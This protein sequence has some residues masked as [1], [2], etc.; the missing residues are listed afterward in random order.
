MRPSV[1]VAAALL[2]VLV[3]LSPVVS[4][5]GTSTPEAAP[6]T[7]SPLTTDAAAL[8]TS[9]IV[10]PLP[11][12]VMIG[13]TIGLAYPHPVALASYLAAVE[14]PGSAHY[15]QFLTHGEFE[16]DFAPSAA[17]AATVA[18]TLRADGGIDVTV[19]PDRLSVSG[20]LPAGSADSLF[21]VSLVSYRSTGGSLE[22][23]AV[24][25]P[26]LPPSWVGVVDAIDGLSNAA[27]A[28]L[29]GLLEVSPF[30]PTPLRV[31][32]SPQYA[33]DNA[34]GDQWF[35]GS[36]Y[37]NSFD[38]QGLLPGYSNSITNATYPTG[39]AIATLLASGWNESLNE[40]TPPWD[41]AVVR[42]YFNDTLAPDWL[43]VS[44]NAS[45]VGVPI[46]VDGI[47][48]PDPGPFGSVNDSTLDT[49]ENA[50]DLEMAGSLAPGASLY[51]FYFAG[52]LLE[53]GSDSDVAGFFDQDLAAALAYNYL[54]LI[55][56]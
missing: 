34:T 27:N 30:V 8:P 42:G 2:V 43:N 37:T 50:L 41:P 51:N 48:P 7:S 35:V 29:A 11:S 36:D 25:T 13:L 32:G 12:S 26:R 54:S 38:V 49:F 6:L 1:S 39:E 16:S 14:S 9:A 53:S 44:R 3:A 20:E 33:T 19:A 15:R 24:G 52:S 5:H 18:G 23:S 47:T 4:A 55:H 10:N 31:G 40:N 21:G 22:Y 28:R 56:I 46:P 17:S 45:L